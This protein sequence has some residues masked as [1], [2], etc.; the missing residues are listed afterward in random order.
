MLT[1]STYTIAGPNRLRRV[2]VATTLGLR[3]QSRYLHDY[4]EHPVNVSCVID[5]ENFVSIPVHIIAMLHVT[6][7]MG[8]RFQLLGVLAIVKDPGLPRMMPV[9]STMALYTY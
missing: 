3:G 9:M 6:C 8:C 4:D 1:D 2:V 7:R 5:L